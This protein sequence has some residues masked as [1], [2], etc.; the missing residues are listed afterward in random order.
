MTSKIKNNTEK[1]TSG[2][3][4][5]AEELGIS[6]ATVDRALHDRG[7]ISEKTR[8]RVLQV[9]EQLNYHPNRAARDLRL[10]RRFRVSINFPTG[11]P[12][13]FDALRSGIEEGALP[14]SSTL[15]IEFHSYSLPYD[16]ARNSIQSALDASVDGII[17]VPPNTFQMAELVRKANMK[18]IPIVCISTDVPESGR[19]TAIT[20]YPFNC[21]AMAAEALFSH[22]NKRGSVG[23]LTGNLEYLNHAEKVRG[24]RTMLS[25]LSPAFSVAAVIEAHDDPHE[26]YQGVR[27]LLQ[28]TPKMA[29]LYISTANSI[30]AL[31]ALREAGRLDSVAVVTTDLIPELVP[32]LREGIVKATIY[33]CPE[34]QGSLAIRTLYWY[35]SEGMRPLHF[36]GV[37]PQ[38]I[39]RS[40]LDLYI[41]TNKYIAR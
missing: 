21:G 1:P 35:L 14:F 22:M 15:D 29:G 34:T 41:S 5:I 9:A 38:L 4:A 33:Q 13:F 24:F 31:T 16:H 26:A 25:Q 32:Y 37:I 23:V 30:S 20:A 6:I 40:N 3:R 27:R 7:R 12:P 19:L 36:I 17:A 10:N 18:G 8:A 39:I 2:I 28:S 11:I